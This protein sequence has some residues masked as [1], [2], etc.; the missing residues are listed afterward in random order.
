MGAPSEATFCPASMCPL[1]AAN[2]SPWTGEKNSKC[3]R[4]RPL[5]DLP[6][7]GCGW[8]QGF[9]GCGCDGASAAVEQIIDVERR[10]STLQL[11]KGAKRFTKQAPKTYDCERAHECPDLWRCDTQALTRP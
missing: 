2:G 8:W 6:G 9:G 7:G 11:G 10:G 5:P 4:A 1:F 3:P